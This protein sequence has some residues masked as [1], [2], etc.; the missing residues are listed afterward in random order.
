MNIRLFILVVPVLCISVAAQA[1]KKQHKRDA[2]N[3]SKTQLRY[4]FIEPVALIDVYNMPSVR[5]G[6]E[7]NFGKR[8]A[9]NATIGTYDF[10]KYF[11]WKLEAKR[12]F[13]PHRKERYYNRCSTFI[14]IQTIMCGTRA[15][16]Y[17]K[18]TPATIL[19]TT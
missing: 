18:E 12:Y 13:R 7:Y 4:F 16:L 6:G 9:V 2:T 11:C 8:Y 3:Y 14:S 19:T 10:N 1:K 5:L 15:A 17:R